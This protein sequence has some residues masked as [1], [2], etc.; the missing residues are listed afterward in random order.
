MPFKSLLV[1]FLVPPSNLALVALVGVLVGLRRSRTG[2]IL[3]VGAVAGLVVLA[4]PISGTLL[5][6]GLE[7]D[8]PTKPAAGAEPGAIVILGGDVGHGEGTVRYVVSVGPLSLERLR[9][10]ARLYRR[11]H[12]PI[13]LTGGPIHP[14]EEPLSTILAR[15]L[16]EDFGVPVRWTET[17]SETTWENAA[18]SAALL[19]REGIGSI[20]LVTHGWHMRRALI[21][22]SHFGIDATAAPVRL[23]RPRRWGLTDFVPSVPGWVSSY[24]GLHEWIGCAAYALR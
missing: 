10:G 1:S 9:A 7:H 22:F 5:I 24:Y 6:W 17:R 11:V 3:T 12:L 21:A 8:L 13:L 2:R 19:K 14:E 23:N 18:E 15:S 20:Y 4:M 16:S